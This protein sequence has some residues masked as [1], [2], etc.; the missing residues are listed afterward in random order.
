[1]AGLSRLRVVAQPLGGWL[2]GLFA[3]RAYGSAAAT[4]LQMTITMSQSQ[5]WTRRVGC[6]EEEYS[7]C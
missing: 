6:L 1:M 7:G 2:L 3:S 5:W 4:Q